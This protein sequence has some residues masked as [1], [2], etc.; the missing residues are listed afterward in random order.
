[1]NKIYLFL[2]LIITSFSFSQEPNA[3]QRAKMQQYANLSFTVSGSVTDSET[4][5]PLEYATVTLTSKRDTETVLGGITGEDGK[6][7]LEVKPGMYSLKIDYISFESYVNENFLVRGNTD[8]GDTALN[9]DV[10]MLDEVEV[11]A[12]R[13]QVEIRLDKKN[14]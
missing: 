8:I 13:T 11:R 14:I 7:S 5:V 9:L 1:M 3:E 12:E 10:S 4:N 6:F 2:L